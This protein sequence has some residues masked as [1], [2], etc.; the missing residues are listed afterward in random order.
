MLSWRQGT[1]EGDRFRKN[2]KSVMIDWYIS[3]RP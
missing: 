3:F 2:I 1:G